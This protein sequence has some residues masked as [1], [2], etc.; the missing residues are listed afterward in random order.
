MRQTACAPDC[1][2]PSSC[3]LNFD[4]PRKIGKVIAFPAM[5]KRPA[6]KADVATSSQPADPAPE[7]QTLFEALRQWRRARA[8]VGALRTMDRAH[9]KDIGLSRLD[10]EEVRAPS[11]A[12][13]LTRFAMSALYRAIHRKRHAGNTD[14]KN[15][16]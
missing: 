16:Q 2:A 3:D 13:M 9:L 8:G 12:S 5:P 11:L 15:A 7:A 14:K 1:C 4:P 6:V 10:L